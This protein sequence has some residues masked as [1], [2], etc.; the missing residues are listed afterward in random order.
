M[1]NKE[2]NE[3]HS[4]WEGYEFAYE[5][6]S[7]WELRRKVTARELKEKYGFKAVPRSLVYVTSRLCGMW[8]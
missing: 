5:V 4:D 3:R 6:M 2:F 8:F 7:V 1:G